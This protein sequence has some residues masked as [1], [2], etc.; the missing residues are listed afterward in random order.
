MYSFP[1]LLGRG[2]GILLGAV[3][4][5]M[6]YGQQN[7]APAVPEK[8]PSPIS[9]HRMVIR[10]GP[11]QRVHY[12]TTGNISTG[13]RI[14]AYNLEA[15]EN[16]LSYARDLQRLKQQYVTSERILEPQRRAVQQELYGKRIQY[17]GYGATYYS[18]GIGSFGAI[19][20]Y[21]GN[22]YGYGGGWGYGRGGYSRGGYATLGSNSYSVVRSLQFGVGDE[23]RMKSALVQV[24]AK[25]ASASYLSGAVRDYENAAARAGASPILS[26]DLGLP[27]TAAPAPSKEQSFPK[28]EQATIWV[29]NDKYTGTVKDDRPGWLVIQTDN[30]EVTV[31]KSEITRT[32]LPSKP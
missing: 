28:G 13:D 31:R 22:P 24:I 9:V 1:V 2:L 5:T 10:E 30:A 19:A 25:E 7:N 26:R 27:K 23:G 16:G 15:A 11:N 17:S 21:Y 8:A 29:G 6:A 20:G 12:I 3:V 14:A 32:E 4:T 18:P